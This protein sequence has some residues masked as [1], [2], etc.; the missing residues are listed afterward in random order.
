MKNPAAPLRILIVTPAPPG[1]RHGNRTTAVRWARHLRGLGHRV[2]IATQWSASPGG[3]RH[4]LLIALHARRSAAALAAWKSAH[5][6]RPAVLVLT[7]TDLYRDIRSDASAQ[8]SL[9]LADRLVL[10]QAEGL[11]ELDAHLR[12]K[13]CVIHQS[14]PAG[15][16]LATPVT[17]ILLTVIG[18]L[19]EEKDPFRAALALARLPADSRVRVVHLGGAMH[20]EYAREARAL[21]KRE[22]RYRWL[23]EL[24]HA[25]A[26]RW[27]AR[28]HAMVISSRMEGG[29]HVVSEAI[30]LGVPVI[31]SRIPGNLGLL[32]RDYPGCYRT[33]DEA[34]LARLM[35]RA[36]REPGFLKSL[37]KAVRARRALTAPRTER[38]ALHALL[39]AVRPGRP[40]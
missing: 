12:R 14:V 37:Q 34:A 23:G 18:H 31:A 7:G 28:S 22:P 6:E 35:L 17:S 15:R 33:G 24:G 29:A 11:A 4:D 38:R 40:A 13:A 27:L 30:A 1:T 5:P 20:P 2:D 3:A 36:E 10:L 8:R 32:G 39:R 21:M 16:R 26:M 9:R 25:Q 19:R